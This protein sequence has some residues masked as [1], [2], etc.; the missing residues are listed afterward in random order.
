[1]LCATDEGLL[2]VAAI[3]GIDARVL[4]AKRV[5][6]GYGEDALPGVIG[7]PPIHL[8]TADDRKAAPQ[9]DKLFVDI[10]AKDK[11]EAESKA[12][13]ARPSPLFHPIRPLATALCAPRRWTTAW[14][15]IPCC[16]F[17]MRPMTAS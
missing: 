11:A 17:W 10:G 3:G 16:G 4:I 2:K 7:A 12:P 1:M 14:A 9:L 5:M 15:C 6:V 13:V 8:Q